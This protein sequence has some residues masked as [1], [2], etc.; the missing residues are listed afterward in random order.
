MDSKNKREEITSLIDNI[1][2]HSDRLSE[3]PS[4]SPA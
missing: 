3:N 4:I 2:T 1:K